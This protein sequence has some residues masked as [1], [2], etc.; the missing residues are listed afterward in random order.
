MKPNNE[1]TQFDNEFCGIQGLTCLPWVGS[2]FYQRS[3][4]KRLLIVGESHYIKA[5]DSEQL[6]EV[7]KL[8]PEAPQFTR[9][10]VS[11]CLVDADWANK[12][13]D[14]IPKVLFRTTE[15]DRPALWRDSAF[16]NFIQRPM[17]DNQKGYR[18]RPLWEDF[19]IGWKVFVDVVNIIQPSHCLFIG[20][21]AAASFDDCMRSQG[22]S[23]V[24]VARTLQVGRTWG[25]SAKLTIAETNI[26]LFFLQHFGKYFS[27]TKWHDYLQVQHTDF[28]NWL[29]SEP[30]VTNQGV[31]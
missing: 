7:C 20:V 9:K 30:Y 8:H 17:H 26:E 6:E 22:L 12:T 29:Q 11:E 4:S 31:Q 23:F 13:L 2:N 19:V 1:T 21:S 27:W 16:Y 18:E 5:E 25:R 3:F 28:M 10:V 24:N 14:T 15:I